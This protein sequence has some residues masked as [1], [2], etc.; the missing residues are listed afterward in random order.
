M[1]DTGS[2]WTTVPVKEL[3][4]RI[5]KRV[6]L[7][8]GTVEFHQEEASYGFSGCDT[9]DPPDKGFSITVNG[10]RV[11]H[12]EETSNEYG[13][14]VFMDSEGE[15][16]PNDKTLTYDMDMGDFYNWLETPNKQE[17]EQQEEPETME[18]ETNETNQATTLLANLVDQA[19]LRVVENTLTR[20]RSRITNYQLN[21][22]ELNVKQTALSI[23]AE[24]VQNLAPARL[25]LDEKIQDY[26]AV[27]AHKALFN[28]V[29]RV[30]TIDRDTADESV[31]EYAET[32]AQAILAA[33]TPDVPDTC[34][35]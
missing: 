33:T 17:Q 13:G 27:E 30:R 26:T 19:P 10:E 34:D 12:T 29:Q 3:E 7:E 11:W 14:W 20:V 9:C 16:N 31:V 18:P 15:Y 28:V 1:S 8:T 35:D 25:N 24:L 6:G 22:N 21:P 4:Q 2:R 5:L 23:F 32:I